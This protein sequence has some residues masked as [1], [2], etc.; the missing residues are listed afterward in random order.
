[1]AVTDGSDASQS[2]DGI[3]GRRALTFAFDGAL[4]ALRIPDRGPEAK[5]RK[6][7]AGSS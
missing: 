6:G 4:Q 5:S 7:V 1:M 3:A 2:V